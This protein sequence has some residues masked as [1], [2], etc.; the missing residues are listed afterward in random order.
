MRKIYIISG[1]VAVSA[2]AILFVPFDKEDSASLTA[3]EIE[4]GRIWAYLTFENVIEKA[5]IRDVAV[6]HK[7]GDSVFAFAYTFGGIRLGQVEANCHRGSA[8]RI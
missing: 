7:D 3:N 1:V 5:L 6:T 4:C 2:V 8:R